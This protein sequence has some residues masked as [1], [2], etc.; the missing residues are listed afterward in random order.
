ATKDIDFRYVGVNRYNPVYDWVTSLKYKGNTTGL[1]KSDHYSADGDADFDQVSLEFWLT[2]PD[3]RNMA[4]QFREIAI[5]SMSYQSTR[6]PM[7]DLLSKNKQV[8]P[9]KIIE[10]IDNPIATPIK[11]VVIIEKLEQAEAPENIF[12]LPAGAKKAQ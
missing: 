4:E 6:K 8:I 9:V 1:F 11:N 3:D 12:D 2:K 5:N 7:A 10:L